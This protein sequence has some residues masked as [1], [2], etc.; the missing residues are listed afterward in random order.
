M[1]EFKNDREHGAERA[2]EYAHQIWVR[3]LPR[4]LRAVLEA[5]RYTHRTFKYAGPSAS[6]RLFDQSVPCGWALL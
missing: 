2:N 4:L 1:K 6:G 5:E 3:A